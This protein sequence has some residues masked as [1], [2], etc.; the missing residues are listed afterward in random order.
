MMEG[1]LIVMRKL[2]VLVREKKRCY[3]E[4]MIQPGYYLLIP[5]TQA[6]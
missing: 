1:L 6:A 2:I 4:T 3:F 5:A